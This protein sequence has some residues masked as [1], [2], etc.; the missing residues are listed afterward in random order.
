MCSFLGAKE[1]KIDTVIWLSC[2]NLNFAS[3]FIIYIECPE[4]GYQSNFPVHFFPNP[5]FQ[6]S[7]PIPI[8]IFTFF[9]FQWPNPSPSV[10]WTPFSQGKTCQSHFP[11]SLSAHQPSI[12]FCCRAFPG[13]LSLD[14][15]FNWSVLW[16][17]IPYSRHTCSH[18]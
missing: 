12:Y 2:A 1:K 13:L 9:P 17:M 18:L 15:I 6:F 14:K 4:G 5:T 7:N 11:F 16:K 10:A 3:F 8:D